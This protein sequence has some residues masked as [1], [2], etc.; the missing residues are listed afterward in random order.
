MYHILDKISILLDL[1]IM[2]ILTTAQLEEKLC[3]SDQALWHDCKQDI[4][5]RRIRK[6]PESPMRKSKLD[7][8]IGY[9]KRKGVSSTPS[10]FA[11]KAC[12][13]ITAGMLCQQCRTSSFMVIH[14]PSPSTTLNP[15]NSSLTSS[16]VRTST[17]SSGSTAVSRSGVLIERPVSPS[18]SSVSNQSLFVSSIELLWANSFSTSWK[19][20]ESSLFSL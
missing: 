14:W 8:F 5:L 1:I 12:I 2:A 13:L 6:M 19:G 16:T 11:D 7:T 17:L 10:I 9:T 3:L 18:L 20:R 15:P 4:Q